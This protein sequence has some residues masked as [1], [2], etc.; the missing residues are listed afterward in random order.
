VTD[1]KKAITAS[2]QGLKPARMPA[3]IMR[4]RLSFQGAYLPLLCFQSREMNPPGKKAKKEFRWF[5][6][7]EL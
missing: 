4:K 3:T 6:S 7:K 1:A 2:R 5:L